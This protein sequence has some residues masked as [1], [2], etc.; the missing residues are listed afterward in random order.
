MRRL[1]MKRRAVATALAVGLCSAQAIARQPAPVRLTL[2]R[3]VG[4]GLSSSEVMQQAEQAIIAA[5]AGVRE[6]K[7]G[8]IPRIDISAQ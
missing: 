8:R 4:M 1:S 5:E 6:A 7:S 3:A 2:E